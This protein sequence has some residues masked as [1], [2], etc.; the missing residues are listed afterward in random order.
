MVV[1]A[2]LE[3]R[4]EIGW[5]PMMDQVIELKGSSLSI[6]WKTINHRI[7]DNRNDHHSQHKIHVFYFLGNGSEFDAMNLNSEY[8]I[9]T[10]NFC[11][12]IEFLIYII[13]TIMHVVCDFSRERSEDMSQ[14]GEM[15]IYSVAGVVIH[16]HA[17]IFHQD[18]RFNLISSPALCGGFLFPFCIPSFTLLFF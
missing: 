9:C 2:T 3:G 18:Y 8:H 17:D 16:I 5:S 13:C 11:I 15:N 4:Q 12:Y 1:N 7:P 10:I 14:N 6:K